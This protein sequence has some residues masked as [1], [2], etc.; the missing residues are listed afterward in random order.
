MVWAAIGGTVL[1]VLGSVGF[2][3]INSRPTPEGAAITRKAKPLDVVVEA[4][5]ALAD[6]LPDKALTALS[7]NFTL[8]EI[9]AQTELSRVFSDTKAALIAE[10]GQALADEAIK[11]AF[12]PPVKTGLSRTQMLAQANAEIDE[13]IPMRALDT[14]RANTTGTDMYQ[15]PEIRA[16]VDRASAKADQL[17]KPIKVLHYPPWHHCSI[18]TPPPSGDT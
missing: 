2:V 16:V 5:R 3:A 7:S 12:L 4:R 10:D 8:A 14:I 1:L 9:E 17:M 6:R 15:D 13:G 11:M 18:K